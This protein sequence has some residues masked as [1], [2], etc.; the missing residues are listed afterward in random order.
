MP[1]AV[2]VSL[3]TVIATS[4]AISGSAEARSAINLRLGFRSS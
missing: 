1:Q 4:N 3:T 2:A